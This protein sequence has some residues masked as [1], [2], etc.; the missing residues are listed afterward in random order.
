MQTK[1]EVHTNG[2]DLRSNH[3]HFSVDVRCSKK[4]HEAP[5]KTHQT[6]DEIDPW[7]EGNK[8]RQSAN[9]L[10]DSTWIYLLTTLALNLICWLVFA[11]S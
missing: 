5:M 10:S 11:W 9:Q 4:L 7:T 2:Q 6:T 8:Q 1:Q 3:R